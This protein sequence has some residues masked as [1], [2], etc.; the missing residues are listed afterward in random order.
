MKHSPDELQERRRAILE[1]AAR[2][3]C[4]SGYDGTSIQDIAQACRLTKAGLYYYVE[5]KEALL[6]QIMAY[7]MDLF[8]E[9]VL[10]QVAGIA[11][12]V[13]RLKTCMAK[14]ITLV[15]RGWSKEIT[16]ILHEHATL[17]GAAGKEINV[18][19]KKYVR[20]LEHSFEEAIEAGLIR[21]VNPKIAA[22][23]MLG[24][25][26]WIYKWFRPAGALSDE[27]LAA[28]MV[29]LFFSGLSL[30]ERRPSSRGRAP[31]KSH[32][33]IATRP[34]GKKR[35]SVARKKEAKGT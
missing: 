15:T 12:P 34:K 11:D 13:L 32:P 22:F 17:R 7:G 2:L 18:R 10:E 20:F 3:I 8:E 23:A 6:S 14:N 9:Q 28:G 27:E 5:S 24:M 35:A 31:S 29:D 33:G 19:K 26:L 1:T 25:V 30:P 21:P 4:D 16:I